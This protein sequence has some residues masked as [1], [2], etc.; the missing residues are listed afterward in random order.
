MISYEL[1]LEIYARDNYT[2]YLCGRKV[3]AGRRK[4]RKIWLHATIDHIIPRS[5]GGNNDLNNLA[6]CCKTCNSHKS[7]RLLPNRPKCLKGTNAIKIN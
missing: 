6:C 2:C 1:R 5:R 4:K 3:N 7:S